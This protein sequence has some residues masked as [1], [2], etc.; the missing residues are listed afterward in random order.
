MKKQRTNI[1]SEAPSSTQPSEEPTVP[2]NKCSQVC[3]SSGKS[4]QPREDSVLEK[5]K[6][7]FG[8]RERRF[9]T[10]CY[11]IHPWLHLCLACSVTFCFYYRHSLEN[12]TITSGL[13]EKSETAFSVVGFNNWK[14]ATQKFK[15]HENSLGHRSANEKIVKNDKR[16]DVCFNDQLVDDQARNKERL[17]TI[18]GDAFP[19]P[20]RSSSYARRCRRRR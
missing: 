3:C 16:I 2:D 13:L 18:K 10:F 20:A 7:T 6:K 5:T 19:P 14:K 9:Q 15:E 11:D 12:G 17:D 4:Y 1:N 8:N